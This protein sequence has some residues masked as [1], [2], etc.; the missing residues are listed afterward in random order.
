MDTAGSAND[1][2]RTVLQ[3]LHILT[4]AGATNAGMALDAHEV[5]DGNDNLLNLLGK[6][7]SGGQN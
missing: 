5:T 4:N 6:F 3:G 2:L 7:A 1:N